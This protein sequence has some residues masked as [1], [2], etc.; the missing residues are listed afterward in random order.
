MQR[1]QLLQSTLALAGASS[2]ACAFR[3]RA[4]C[5]SGSEALEVPVEF[6]KGFRWGAASSSYQTEGAVH[7]D[8]R[9]ESV[10]DRFSHTPGVVKNGEANVRPLVTLYHWDIPQALV[11]KGGWA[12]CDMVARFT[13]YAGIMASPVAGTGRARPPRIQ[14]RGHARGTPR[15]ESQQQPLNRPFA[16]AYRAF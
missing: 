11:D 9:G 8:G 14:R 10:W 4:G 2:T 5:R 1:R 16:Q 13:E 6:P 15:T 3:A 7:E 12:N